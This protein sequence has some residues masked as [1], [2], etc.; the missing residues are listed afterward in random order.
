MQGGVVMIVLVRH[1][2]NGFNAGLLDKHDP[3]FYRLTQRGIIQC[4]QAAVWLNAQRLYFDQ[5]FHS[6]TVRARQTGHII[7]PQIAWQEE[8]LL[9]EISRGHEKNKHLDARVEQFF[10]NGVLTRELN[11]LIVS[12]EK[13]IIRAVELLT[14]KEFLAD[15]DIENGQITIL[16]E[17]EERYIISTIWIPK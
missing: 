5:G 15:S 2:E 17:E 7:L 4:E 9:R 6:N 16:E 13:W 3:N 14:K 1:G 12:H 10:T 8:P 11:I